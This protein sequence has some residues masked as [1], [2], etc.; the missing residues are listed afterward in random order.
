MREGYGS[1]LVCVCLSVCLYVCLSV[2]A[3]AATFI[4]ATNDTHG[5]LLALLDFKRVEFRKTLPFKREKANM[6]MIRAH[7]EP[8][9]R[10][11]GTNE[12]QQLREG[13]LVGRML[14]QRVNNHPSPSPSPSETSKI[15]ARAYTGHSMRMRSIIHSL[16]V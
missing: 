1:C 10:S 13:Q 7:R 3:L 12:T 6:Q 16:L 9:S 11:L 5:F 4:P 14:L 15:Q 2:T 8:F